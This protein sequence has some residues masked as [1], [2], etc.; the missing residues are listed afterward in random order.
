[1]RGHPTS[2][3]LTPALTLT[4]FAGVTVAIVVVLYAYISLRR[5]LGVN[6]AQGWADISQALAFNAASASL[7]SLA[8]QRP[9]A[10]YWRP[11][12]LLLLP[13]HAAAECV[14]LAVHLASGGLLL[15]G[16]ALTPHDDGSGG[17]GGG[18]GG[19]GGGSGGSGSMFI[20]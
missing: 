11:A 1:M 7:R 19:G 5:D 15:A 4:S 16:R 13:Q 20:P 12:L 8:R 2:L 9:S 6:S 3:T 14:G 17:S 18:G 10:K